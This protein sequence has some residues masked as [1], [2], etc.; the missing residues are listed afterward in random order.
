MPSAPHRVRWTDHAL[1]KA[2]L[3]GITRIDVEL[4]VI[5]HHHRRRRNARSADWLVMMGRLVIAYDHPDHADMTT[6]RV[7]TLWRRR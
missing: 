6:A 4:L 3:L 1:E 2:T 7:I 5:E